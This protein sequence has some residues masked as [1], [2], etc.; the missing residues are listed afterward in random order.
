MFY[1]PLNETVR[2]ELSLPPHS[3][4]LLHD[5]YDVVQIAPKQ[6]ISSG[7]RT[8][9][10]APWQLPRAGFSMSIRHTHQYCTQKENI[11]I[12]VKGSLGFVILSSSSE[13][14]LDSRTLF[15]YCA[16]GPSLRFLWKDRWTY[17]LRTHFTDACQHFPKISLAT[18]YIY[19]TWSFCL[20]DF[21]SKILFDICI[22]L[23]K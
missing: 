14:V 11:T 23:L 22:Q 2:I 9:N 3:L 19:S 16:F 12:Y 20:L 13:G 6:L 7:V 1:P 5:I 4:Q 18:L 10:D 17:L 21:A 8:K 15:S